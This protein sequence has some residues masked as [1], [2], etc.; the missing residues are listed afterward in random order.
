MLY[1]MSYE[2]TRWMVEHR[3][4]IAEV[5]G[6]NPLKPWFFFWLL[7]SNCLSWK[8]YCDNHSSLSSTTAVNTFEF[9]YFL[10]V[11][12]V[13]RLKKADSRNV[14]L[15]PEK[16]EVFFMFHLKIHIEALYLLWILLLGA[17]RLGYHIYSGVIISCIYHIISLLTE[18]YRNSINWPWSQCMW[19]HSSF[20]RASQRYRGDRVFKSRYS[21]DFFFSGFCFPTA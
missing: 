5:T 16:L 4:S 1:R 3:T 17:H 11:N 2:A 10:S 13:P 19:L 15:K 18:R 9:L 20:G 21:A 6:S 7:L 8:I 14:E 12:I